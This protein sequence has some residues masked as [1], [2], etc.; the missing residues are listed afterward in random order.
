MTTGSAASPFTVLRTRLM[1]DATP[2]RG[3][4]PPPIERA[5]AVV[6]GDGGASARDRAVVLRHALRYEHGQTGGAP[7]LWVPSGVNWPSPEMWSESGVEIRGHH[8]GGYLV[9]ALPWA[10]SWLPD[11]PTDG[12][13]GRAAAE[14]L[15][16][17]PREVGPDPF[18]RLFEY[19]SYRS[20]GQRAALRAALGAP[21]GSTL[22]VCLP[23]GEGKSL[24]FQAIAR[25][26][27]G[28]RRGLALVVTPTVALALDHERAARAQSIEGPLTYRAGDEASNEM[29]RQRIRSGEQ[30]ICYASPEAVCGPLR[31]SVEHA[32][33]RGALRALVVDEAH[34]IDSWGINFRPDFQVLAG[35]R[36]QLI[37]EAPSNGAFRT[38]LLSATLTADTIQTLRALFPPGPGAAFGITNSAR[39]RPEIEYWV[40]PR[41]GDSDE[42]GQ[43]LRRVEEAV[44]NLPRPAILYTTERWM[45]A[46][47]FNRLRSVGLRR[48]GLVTGETPADERASVIDAWRAG[49]MDLVVGTSAFGLGI[50]NPNVRAVIHAC[51]PETLDRFYQEVGRGGRSGCVSVSLILPTARDLEMAGSLNRRRLLTPEVAE[52]RWRAMF[53]DPERRQRADGAYEVRVTVPPARDE[54]HI[55]MV[56][57]RNTGWN[58]R[59]LVLLAAA[60]AITLVDVNEDLTERVMATGDDE[61]E[62]YHAPVTEPES[63]REVRLPRVALRILDTAHA[64]PDFWEG[65]IAAFRQAQDASAI[66]SLE[67]MKRFLTGVECAAE[68]LAPLYEVS[69]DQVPGINAI[70]VA[71]ACGG[72]PAC[73]RAG[74]VAFEEDVPLSPFPWPALAPTPPVSVLIGQ[75]GHLLVDLAS[76]SDDRLDQRDLLEAL[77]RLPAC[78]VRNAV[79]FPGAP[80]HADDIELSTAPTLFTEGDFP[81][82]Q[83][84]PGPTL[85]VLGEETEVSEHWFAPRPLDLARIWLIPREVRHPVRRDQGLCEVPPATVLT[86][87]EFAARMRR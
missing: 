78:G 23:T 48:L 76:L 52:R 30:E 11:V 6:D 54:R 18:L 61:G 3:A 12:V 45:A 53:H 35:L 70:P 50:D 1:G 16:R 24:V 21:A 64:S 69:T 59:T 83:L 84:P 8:D 51:V 63:E 42:A 81:I 36:R 66:Q 73:R 29:L 55:D 15:F 62:N 27:Y 10:P 79:I 38:V 71:R 19:S 7:L 13:D 37:A 87:R 43:R 31:D 65:R 44:L 4:V 5:L 72:C 40:T 32:A 80:F 56:G 9:A 75:A 2:T 34:L 67:R 49:R 74:R 77:Q 58:V 39:L 25:R 26:G 22:V 57:P 20:A 47:W 41:S 82:N 86:S 68:T 33:R 85:V 60:G 14:Q 46:D 17:M 28:G